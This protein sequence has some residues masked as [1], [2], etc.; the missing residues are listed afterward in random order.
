MPMYTKPMLLTNL[1]FPDVKHM[2]DITPP[3][4][5]EDTVIVSAI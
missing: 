1:V 5:E 3:S 2:T 4:F